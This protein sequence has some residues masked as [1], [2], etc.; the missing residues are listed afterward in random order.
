MEINQKSDNRVIRV[1]ISSTFS[2]MQME[3]DILI[4]KI[5]P[6]LRKL[7]EERAVTWTEVD[8]RWGITSEEASEGKVL[9]LCLAEIQRCRPYFIGLLGERYGWVPNEDDITED[10][11][12]TQPWIKD[13]HGHS[14]TELEIMQGVMRNP[15]MAS[16]SFFY[17]R[18]PCYV[19]KIPDIKRMDYISENDISHTK[20]E[21]LKQ[22]IRDAYKNGKLM[23]APCEKY[24]NPEA[25][26]E[27]VLSDFTNLIEKL[28]PK[29]NV[30]DLLDQEA[31]RHEA[32][33]AS[34]RLAFVGRSEL[35]KQIDDHM[36]TV[37]AKP[38]VLTGYSGCGKSALLAE[39][40]A[41]WKEKNPE[42]LVIQHYIGSTPESANWQ[43]LVHRILGELKRTYD[44]TDEIPVQPE[45]LRT[46][47]QIWL[48]KAAGKRR[49]I[50]V[51]DALNQLSADDPTAQQL[52]W[53]PSAFPPNIRLLFSAL[54]GESLEALRRRNLPELNVPLFNR[55]D[56]VPVAEA[57]FALF[58]KKLPKDILAKLEI[59]PAATNALYLRSVLDELRQFGQHEKLTDRADLYLSASNLPDLFDRIL[60]RWNEDFGNEKG[61]P[62]IVR[63]SLCLI[64][65]TR[66]G[67]S[68]AELLDLLGKD[69]EPLPRRYWTP[70]YLAA[71]NAMVQH[72]GLL[73]FGH[74]YLRVAVLQH[75][76][77]DNSITQS[78]RL[79][80]AG[81]FGKIPEPTD[82]KLDELPKLQL[83]TSQYER[84]KDF[85]TD[86][87]TFF[88]FR[89]NERWKWELHGYWLA[90]QGRF[91]PVQCYLHSLS[92]AEPDSTPKQLASMLIK[93]AHFHDDAGRYEGAEPLYRRT[94]DIREQVLGKDHPDTLS[95]M[96]DLSLLLINKNE[97]V[98]ANMLCHHILEAR[99][100]VLGKEHPATLLSMNNLAGLLMS[101][102]DYYGAEPLFR[103]VLEARERVLGNEHPDTLQSVGN[104]A[105]LLYY[106][107]DYAGS[108]TL[109]LR[110]LEG[111]ERTLGKEHPHTLIS[112]D[113][114]ATLF[115]IKGDYKSAE[116]LYHRALEIGELVLGKE[117]PNTLTT[118][119][120][121]AVLFHAKGDYT[122]A[123]EHYLRV[124][125]GRE[126]VLGKEH[127]DT[128]SS[129]NNLAGL[130]ESKGDH[131]GAET[132]YHRVLEIR[133]RVLGK[134][135]PD[136][137][138]TV[139]QLAA[140]FY[141][142][143]DYERAK[144]YLNRV[145]ETY[146]RGL[147]MDNPDTLSSLNSLADLIRSRGDQ[148]GAE[149]L[150]IQILEARERVLG[151]EHPDTITSMNNL[152][153]VF[154]DKR[155]YSK[156]EEL[157]RQALQTRRCILGPEH[158]D[159]LSSISNLAHL[160]KSKGDSAKEEQQLMEAKQ[161]F[162]EAE[163]LCNQALEGRER[164][165]GKE[166][167]DTLTS[168][169][170]LAALLKSLGDFESAEKLYRRALNQREKM[171]G[172]EHPDTL[173]SMN[174]LAL[175]LKDKGEYDDAEKIF[176][177][178]IEACE[179]VL[180]LEH[181]DTLVAVNNLAE[182]HKT[183]GDF[184]VAESL[185]RRAFVG[186]IHI[187]QKSGQQHP[188]F[189]TVAGN[190]VELLMKTGLSQ[191][192][193]IQKIQN[194][195]SSN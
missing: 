120:N 69:N 52:D 89:M 103:R 51:L 41:R 34:R 155:E 170:N 67:L 33:A 177:D 109:N 152:A 144:P 111:R 135:H 15:G 23:F 118:L 38:I 62:D 106:M 121:L 126:R 12:E 84:L 161:L 183:M 58:S 181:P 53:V 125:Q 124:L 156:A 77:K 80:L 32:Y 173:T 102:K 22:R 128:L 25:F 14:V 146:E 24:S 11:L 39:W 149:P 73:T 107:G 61:Y 45:V 43:S 5:F 65:S 26:G 40:S 193:A 172:K 123:E 88:R 54:S 27:Q 122:T 158:P 95:S 47:L 78:F 129:M 166:H 17:F 49:V 35:L 63:R 168:V 163:K 90:L 2:D 16:R 29:E 92:I 182:L 154:H 143:E 81:Y 56:I 151:K 141:R 131:T 86:L 60:T 13:H 132:L 140:L 160:L 64:A 46:A 93:V 76:L 6:Q 116:L 108:E 142:K 98:E 10:L 167:P 87:P 174:N 82:R 75:W 50:L 130:L 70:F 7:C 85:L 185:F 100:R 176:N 114:L 37:G 21:A 180:G 31:S 66:F 178:A 112:V 119:S 68:E 134:E 20:L 101:K 139:I 96:N 83:D 186:L 115:N 117:H 137:L 110:A 72:S 113:S 104:L 147:G 105:V 190:Y 157:Y 187:S 159:T 44:I 153:V 94:L 9:P 42:D 175:V 30:P 169:N 57:Y 133:E 74:D 136:T 97:F 79:H 195:L 28:Y 8:L 18:D 184:M 71:E 150:L 165:L 138:I 179:R 19:E 171:L 91:D 48:T 145:Q 148:V 188:Y 162:T 1:F 189:S 55:T 3:R 4:K 36:S 59:T 99:E 192:Q 194:M 164:V 191:I 127:P